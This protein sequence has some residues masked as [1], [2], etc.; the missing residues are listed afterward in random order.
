MDGGA[1]FS[2]S[3][4]KAVHRFA[5]R[6]GRQVWERLEVG[7]QSVFPTI[8]GGIFEFGFPDAVLQMWAAFLAERAEGL[9]ERSGCAT[10]ADAVRSRAKAQAGRPGA[11]C[12]RGPPPT[13]LVAG[14]LL[15]T[16]RTLLRWHQ[17][18][19]RRTWR[20]AARCRRR[21]ISRCSRRR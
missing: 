8:T 7:S 17:S 10:P 18:L 16:P 11:D 15:V 6:E 1:S 19:V 4:P 5:I 12:G 20:Q 13:A 14:V 9:G 2:T 3:E 21:G